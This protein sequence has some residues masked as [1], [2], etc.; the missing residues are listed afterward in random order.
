[1]TCECTTGIN[2]KLKEKNLKLVL[3]FDLK[4]GVWPSIELDR[5]DKKKR[6]KII[7]LVPTFCPFCGVKYGG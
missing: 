4:G 5:I 3:L 6:D 1:M 7:P 2:E